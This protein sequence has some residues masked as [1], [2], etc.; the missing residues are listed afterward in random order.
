MEFLRF[1]W[2]EAALL[3]A[4]AAALDEGQRF[5]LCQRTTLGSLFEAAGLTEVKTQAVNVPTHFSSFDDYWTP[6]LQG[7]G[8]APS[9]VASL[10]APNREALRE[11][12]RRRLPADSDG[13]IQLRARAWAVRGVA[14]H[15]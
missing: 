1:F 12:L 14:S 4:G 6:F 3:D 15:A 11:Q 13:R 10:G 9:Y 8:P 7:T 2:D 5:P